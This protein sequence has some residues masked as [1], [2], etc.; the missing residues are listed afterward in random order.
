MTST[1][2][3]PGPLPKRFDQLLSESLRLYRQA[4]PLLVTI[5][6]I[7]S[8][9]SSVL[10][11]AWI[12][13]SL[14]AVIAWFLATTVP[15]LITQAA[16]TATAWRVG[17]QMP[18]HPLHGSLI[19][20]SVAPIYVAGS[21]LLI[22]LLI[23]TLWA[24]FSLVGLPIAA[25]GLFLLTRWGLFGPLV[26]VEQRRVVESLRTSWNLVSGRTWRTMGMLFV[27]FT[28]IL[29]VL[30]LVGNVSSQA[31]N[32]VQVGVN[33]LAQATMI[34]MATIFMLLLYED[35]RRLESAP[36]IESPEPPTSAA[37]Q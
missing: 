30:V 4:F 31:P 29:V 9:I 20:L 27:I 5:T 22:L 6:A 12:P 18:A 24:A 15:I 23:A 35:Y 19:A 21:L 1:E 25:L 16:V 10:Q 28:V 17:R 33:I 36:A 3:A 34:P 2:P 14:A 7:G 8:L 26:I 37:S 32:V 13:E 11:T